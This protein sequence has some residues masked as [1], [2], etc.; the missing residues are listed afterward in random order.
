MNQY[1]YAI[2]TAFPNSIVDTGRLTVEVLESS[3]L[4]GL[5]YIN[6]G[7]GNCD[8][9]FAAALSVGELATL[10]GIV[11]AHSGEPIRPWQEIAPNPPLEPVEP[12][13]SIVIANNI[14]A[15]Q[16][17]DG[18]TGFGSV[19]GIWPL[20]QM[21]QAQLRATVRFIL[22]AVGTGTN[23]RLALKAKSHA[24]GEDSSEGFPYTKFIVVPID[25]L[26]IG[27][28]FEGVILFTVPL[29][30]LNDT[31]AVHIGRDGANSMGA[32]VND[33]VNQPIQIISVKLEAC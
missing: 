32:G 16:I 19:G 28:V 2:A 33:D 23:V 18:V 15:V 30:R 3:I 12:G 17:E 14:P 7:L 31:L 26:E 9:W 27:E 5:E 24:A 6:T 4:T 22:P 21:T 13:S 29:F 20:V 25:Y 11:A 10:D 1:T 8:I